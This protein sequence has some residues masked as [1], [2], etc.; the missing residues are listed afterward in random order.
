MLN[1]V[2]GGNL[3]AD[4]P[5]SNRVFVE[6]VK[7]GKLIAFYTTGNRPDPVHNTIAVFIVKKKIMIKVSELKEYMLKDSVTNYSAAYE[8]INGEQYVKID[9]LKTYLK[10]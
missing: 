1:I 5:N 6:Q 10:K 4:F 7:H 3:A 2:T 8:V 9:C